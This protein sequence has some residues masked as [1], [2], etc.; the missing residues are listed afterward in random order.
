MKKEN[1]AQRVE[2]IKKEKSGLDVLSDI[3]RY[4]SSLNEI[5]TEDID[6][7]KWYGLYTQNKNEQNADDNNLYFMLRIKLEKGMMNLE[8]MKVISEIS[9]LF[10]KQTATF[11]TRQ[12]IQLH[13]VLVKNLP[14]IFQRL[15]NV[16]LSTVFAAGDVP[17]NIVTCPVMGVDHDELVDVTKTVEEVNDFF[18]GNT[19][20]A[21]LPRKYKVGISACSKHCMGHEI[22]DLSFT[23]C[24]LENEIFF[25]VSVG[26]GLGSNKRLA[27]HIGYIKQENILS[28]VKAISYIYR[29]YGLRENRKKA[30]LGH[31]I[32]FWGVERFIQEVGEKI[33]FKFKEKN[34]QEYT[35]YPKR[36]HFGTHPSKNPGL[37]YIGCAINGG[38]IGA[39][40]LHD[41]AQS[42]EKYNAKG[43]RATNT[44]NF[45]IIDV[46]NNYTKA[47]IKELSS[48]NI[49]A[50]PSVFKARTISCTGIQ[51]CKFAISETKNQAIDLVNHLESKFPNFDETIS[52]S[53]NGCPN[54]CAHPHIVDIGLMGT[55]FK[56]KNGETVTGFDVI[57]G[58]NLQGSLS[59][60]G[61]KVKLKLQANQINS[62]I[63]NIILQYI[64]SNVPSFNKFVQTKIN[65]ED[66][67]HE[68][69]QNK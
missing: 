31:L 68:V 54:S 25:D 35:P 44:Q 49:D 6:R 13:N 42:L 17:R 8:Q 34:P 55:K 57:L 45:V 22:Q 67:I 21:N 3:Y 20:L 62:T 39:K 58:G 40:G 2:R 7:F 52:I 33:G 28:V 66:F 32:E 59:H 60:F 10:S 19:E 48:Q 14:E 69:S 50:N 12:D 11:T 47:L 29:D 24:T 61:E 41:L 1:A 46:P 43:I 56:D 23:A 51:F 53:A 37:S 4:A 36:E 26:G 30:R 5:D 38:K 15:Q 27:T 16:G 18:R 9:Y 64:K 63:E 65:D